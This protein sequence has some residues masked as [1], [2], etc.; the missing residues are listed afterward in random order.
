[1]YAVSGLSWGA[2]TDAEMRKKR[3][4]TSV[5]VEQSLVARRWTER[6]LYVCI[7][8]FFVESVVIC[9]GVIAFY[10]LPSVL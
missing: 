1:M 2:Y 9:V 5:E 10:S 7:M 6:L 3:L 8:A 4:L